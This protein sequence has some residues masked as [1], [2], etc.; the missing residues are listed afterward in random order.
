MAVSDVVNLCGLLDDAKCFALVRQHRW[1]TGARCPGCDS[2]AITRDGHDDTQP[3]RQRYRCKACAGR[4]DDLTGTVLAGHHQPL[5]AWV[6]CLYLMGLN[7]SNRQIAAELD[8]NASDVQAMTERL[9]TGLV[10][11]AGGDAA[12][13]DGDRRSLRRGRS[14]GP[15]GGSV[16]K[17]RPGRCRRL[18]G[19]PGH[20][21]LEKDKPPILG[22]I[23]RGGQVVLHMLANVQQATIKPI[24]TDTVAAGSL[25]HTDEYGVYARL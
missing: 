8:L 17:G 6:L 1:P 4:F 3:D 24:I 25:I 5:R 21:T 19:A 13:R 18:A 10:E 9:R 15:A 12:G 2:D 11:G 22:L 23:E 14:Q 7:L 16:K 20:G